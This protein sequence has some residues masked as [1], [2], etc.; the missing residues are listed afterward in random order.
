[1]IQFLDETD[2]LKVLLDVLI[3]HPENYSDEDREE[4]FGKANLMAPSILAGTTS[5]S[6]VSKEWMRSAGMIVGAG[7]LIG[8]VGLGAGID[9]VKEW[10]AKTISDGKKNPKKK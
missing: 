5:R 4:L 6:Y 3:D 7:A 10:L 2:M 8:L 1:M 9:A